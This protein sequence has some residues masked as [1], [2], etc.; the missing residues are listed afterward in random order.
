MRGSNQLNLTTQVAIAGLHLVRLRIAI[1]RRAALKNVGDIDC[2]ARQTDGTQHLVKQ[3]P[4]PADKRFAL[5]I[6]VRTRGFADDQ[7]FGIGV[8]NA[9]Y[10]P[11][12][13]LVQ[14]AARAD[15]DFGRQR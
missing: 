8:T 12:T 15:R 2:F 6:L 3:L 10:C 13:R 5:A 7:P 11:G 1:V 14:S 9:K 4:G